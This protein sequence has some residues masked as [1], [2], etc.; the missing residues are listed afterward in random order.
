MRREKGG[1]WV[2]LAAAVFYPL[3]FLTGRTRY[4]GREHLPAVGG[5][6]LVA[7]HVSHL[8]P[9]HTALFVHRAGRVPRF[10][11]KHNLWQVPV[12]GTVLLGSG[13]IPVHRD[14]AD[15]QRS[16]NAGVTALCNGKIVVIYPEGTITRDPDGWPMQARTGMA[17]LALNSDVPVVPVAHWGTR[18]VYDHNGKR[19]RPLPRT[20]ITVRAGEPVDLSGYRGRPVDAVLLREVTDLVMGRVRDLLA[21]VRGAPAPAGFYRQTRPS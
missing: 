11:A 12:L 14:S 7:N 17:R 2:A 6:L 18:E 9:V 20:T 15:A 1:V 19:F 21:E 5:A 3:G 4:D 13:Q 10:M 8:D 16:L